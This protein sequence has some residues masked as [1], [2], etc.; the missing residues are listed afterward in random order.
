MTRK[1]NRLSQFWHELKRRNVTR[2][3]A[4]YIAAGFMILELVGMMSDSFGLPEWSWKVT[5]FILLAG[6]IIAVIVS[7]I[8]DITP[9]GIEKT[10]PSS[11][12]EEGEEQIAPPSW[13]NWKVATYISVV[14]I[15][16]LILFNIFT[17]NIDNTTIKRFDT[18][19]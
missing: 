13:K 9:E 7:W 4:V 10:I 14:V 12:L 19:F 18:T 15:I 11:E 5:F 2:V 16:G 6:L 3:L 8:Y 1:Q 17:R